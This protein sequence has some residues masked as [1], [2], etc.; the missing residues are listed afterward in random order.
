MYLIVPMNADNNNTFDNTNIN[1]K[2]SKWATF[3]MI[4][5]TKSYI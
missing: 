4:L 3:L 2:Y 1:I 5:W